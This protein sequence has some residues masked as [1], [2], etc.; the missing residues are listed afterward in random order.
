LWQPELFKQPLT[1]LN[2]SISGNFGSLGGGVW[3]NGGTLTVLNSSISGNF[4]QVGN[5]GG[6][7][8]VGGLLTVTN[9]TIADN[10][11]S[12][13][14]DA[15]VGGGGIVNYGGTATITN[16]TI[17]G[18]RAFSSFGS[19]GGGVY[20][21]GGLFTVI[22]STITGNAGFLE[23]GGVFNGS[24]YG[25]AAL[26]TLTRTL[27]AGN[28]AF[29][30]PEM[31]N[32][33][34]TGTVVA[35]NHNLFGVNGTAGVEGFSPGVTDVVPP[36]GVQLA[37]ILDPTLAFNGGFKQTHALVPGSPAIDAGDAV[38]TDANDD[39]LLSDQ[40]GRP[41]VVDGD[42]DG[43]AACD[44]GAFEFFPLVNDFVTL[45]PDLD[46]AF[47]PTPGPAAPAGTFTITA[48]F[49]NTSDATLHV[50]FFLVTELSGDNL[51]LNAEEGVQ[52]VG[53]TMP[54][55]G[56]GEILAPGET[57]TVEFVIGLQERA[58]F[59]FFVDLFGEPLP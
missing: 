58:P 23:G 46:T 13:I 36:A 17:T 28:T 31:F 38:C 41:R 25:P 21:A 42:G 35:A 32:D 11:V 54:L 8:N 49:A 5:G 53:A 22:N 43:T 1:V 51:V 6:V 14:V 39:P 16:S 47:D 59:R 56:E 3:N 19:R 10:S 52:G 15:P 44:I 48:T 29:R 9:S 4:A 30:G 7:Y 26:L 34:T 18:N 55:V 24:R 40:R 45:A 27:V 50:P 20:N 57:V 37:D 12:T 33:V 2:S